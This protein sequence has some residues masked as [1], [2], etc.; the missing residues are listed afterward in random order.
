MT[1]EVIGTFIEAM[2]DTPSDRDQIAIESYGGAVSRVSKDATGFEHRHSPFNL[3]I[4]AI[5]TDPTLDWA[6][7]AWARNLYQRIL[8]H[9]TGGTYVNY[10]S[11]RRPHSLRGRPFPPPGRHQSPL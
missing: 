7:V 1:D 10:Q 11:A 3:L 5:S 2:R 6:D 4:L 8:P 9:S